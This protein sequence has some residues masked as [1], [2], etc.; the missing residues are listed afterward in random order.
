MIRPPSRPPARTKKHSTLA[1]FP[2]RYLMIVL[3]KPDGKPYEF[4]DHVE[5]T[6]FIEAN[7]LGPQVSPVD[8]TVEPD[9]D[10]MHISHAVAEVLNRL[11]P[12]TP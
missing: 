11:N 5:A 1:F 8:V 6:K 9:L 3:L 12:P 10:E 7:Q 4:G 2:S